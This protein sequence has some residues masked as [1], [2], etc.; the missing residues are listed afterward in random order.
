MDV[1]LWRPR[2]PAE[3]QPYI[4]GGD[5]WGPPVGAGRPCGN[6][7]PA[8]R[9]G[10]ETPPSAA[11]QW[12][13]CRA[14]GA[15]AGCR[16]MA[17]AVSRTQKIPLLSP[18]AKGGNGELHHA[19][20]CLQQSRNLTPPRSGTNQSAAQAHRQR[21][22]PHRQPKPFDKL[23]ANGPSSGQPPPPGKGQIKAPAGQSASPQPCGCTGTDRAAG[24]THPAK[25]RYCRY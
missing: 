9:G 16:G 10:G 24:A 21:S 4:N 15:S 1:T 22:C 14:A 6:G 8:R 19:V 13:I 20:A 2:R 5:R 17:T 23:R 7:L 12:Q 18:F 3:R 11:T 25:T